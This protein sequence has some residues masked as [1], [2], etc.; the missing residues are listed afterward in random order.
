[1]KWLL[2]E[3]VSEPRP[4]NPFTEAF[5]ER[6]KHVLLARHGEDAVLGIVDGHSSNSV[7]LNTYLNLGTVSNII[8]ISHMGKGC[9]LFS[10]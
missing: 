6:V 4:R 10:P 8:S 5:S 2:C 3:L 7:R 1:M 9:L